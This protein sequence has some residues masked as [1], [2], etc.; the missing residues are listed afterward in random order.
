[1]F[2]SQQSGTGGVSA[3]ATTTAE[4]FTYG[5]FLDVTPHV[6]SEGMITM[7]IHP[8]VSNFIELADI[9]RWC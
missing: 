5:V 3:I 8:S 1:M 2:Q 9:S 4:P 7:D 6:D